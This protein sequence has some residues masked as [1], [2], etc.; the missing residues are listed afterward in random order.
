MQRG[1]RQKERNEQLLGDFRVDGGAGLELIVE[2][3]LPLQHDQ[4]AH[5]F[6]GQH[7]RRAHHLLHDLRLL[8]CRDRGEEA[9]SHPR[10]R[11]PDVV[12]EEHD[13]DDRRPVDEVGED[14]PQRHELE[15]L[16]EQRGGAQDHQSPEDL[17]RAGAAEHHQQPVD[18]EPDDGD[19]E[20]VTNRVEVGGVVLAEIAQQLPQPL[21]HVRSSPR[22]SRRARPTATARTA[23]DTA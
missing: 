13:D 1:V 8:L 5:A 14:Q 23:P 3:R 18:A 17:D 19:V 2:P 16:G 20:D 10:Q 12:L 11:P 6:L 15:D 4:R 21:D 9:A 22:A 7:L